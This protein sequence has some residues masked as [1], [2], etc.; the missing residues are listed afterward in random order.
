MN[1]SSGNGERLEKIKKQIEKLKGVDYDIYETLGDKDATRY[2]KEYC[3]QNPGEP[4]RFYACGGDG[5]IN[6]VLNGMACHDFAELA[7][8]PCGS[9]ND[10]V[11]Y[12]G[13]AENFSDISALV[14][15][16]ASPI[17][18]IKVGDTYSANIVNFGFDTCVARTMIKVKDKKHIGGKNAYN[19]GILW[20]VLTA[21]RNKG[22]VYADG[23]LLNTKKKF[24]LCTVANGQYV[25]GAFRCAPRSINNDGYL[26]V[27][28]VHTIS[29]FKF[30]KLLGSYTNGKHL[31]DPR[32]SDIIEYRRCRKVTVEAPEGFAISCDGEI[33]ET[34]RF[35]CEV[36][37]SAVKFV[38]PPAFS[39]NSEAK[40]GE[41]KKEAAA[42]T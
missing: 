37:P 25:G 40:P 16:E 38:I 11:K 33:I 13:G 7:C 8:I 3:T 1:P 32:F 4:V 34:N 28:L 41:I 6:E 23:E 17:D 20:A 24:L 10:F 18:I 15:T 9:G 27:C 30:I 5:T 39:N 36:I 22:K 29:R 35:T 14:N 2:A 42:T 26:D 19:T 31:D 21:M 12:Y